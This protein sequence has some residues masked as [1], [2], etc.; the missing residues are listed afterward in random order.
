MPRPAGL[1]RI[2]RTE[3]MQGTG[4]NGLII[5]FI[6]LSSTQA[7]GDCCGSMGVL[8]DGSQLHDITE[9][10]GCCPQPSLVDAQNGKR[11]VFDQARCCPEPS[12]GKWCSTYGVAGCSFCVD[13][14][15]E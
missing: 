9:G 2:G 4:W 15:E 5:L 10:K 3:Q 14:C 12:E 7:Q 8:P 1:I 13:K 6:L 11:I